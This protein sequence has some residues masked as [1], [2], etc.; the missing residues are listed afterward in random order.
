MKKLTSIIGTIIYLIVFVLV[1]SACKD[2]DSD[3]IIVDEELILQKTAKKHKIS[4][5]E[6]K[7]VI[8]KILIY[9][10]D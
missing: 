3:K 6:V 10:F 9:Q 5:E 2:K 1:G 7:E 8:T 4:K